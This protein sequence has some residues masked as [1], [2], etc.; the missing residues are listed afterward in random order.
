MSREDTQALN[1]RD[2]C[3]ITFRGADTESIIQGL[4]YKECNNGD[5]SMAWVNTS[6][7][8]TTPLHVP[9]EV[10][11]HFFQRYMFREDFEREPA[12]RQAETSL[13]PPDALGTWGSSS[14]RGR[15]SLRSL[16]V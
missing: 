10:L 2:K 14:S 3:A 15:S 6:V 4:F 12:P 8:G 9:P 1:R 7:S 13:D 16:T 11:F 5:K